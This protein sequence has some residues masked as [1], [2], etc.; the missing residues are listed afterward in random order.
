MRWGWATA[1][2]FLV[3]ISAGLTRAQ[4]QADACRTGE[5]KTA[6]AACTAIIRSGKASNAELYRAYYNRGV[7]YRDGKHHALAVRDFTEAM[8]LDP[9]NSDAVL[10]RGVSYGALGQYRRSIPD[11]TAAIELDPGKADAWNARCYDRAIIGELEKALADC[12]KALQLQPDYPEGRDS[13]G[14]VYL[15]LRRYDTAITDYDVALELDPKKAVSLYGRG[16]ARHAKGDRAGGD[17]DIAAA[18]ALDPSLPRLFR[19]MGVRLR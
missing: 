12:N 18:K 7:L 3:L 5:G 9:A 17:A 10:N 1:V 15:K 16:L 8:R 19:E 13:R 6:I 14:F 2:A 11:Y 4:S